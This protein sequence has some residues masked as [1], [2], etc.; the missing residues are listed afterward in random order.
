MTL[1]LMFSVPSISV[2]GAGGQVRRKSSP[3]SIEKVKESTLTGVRVAPANEEFAVWMPES[4]KV[5]TEQLIIDQRPLILSYYGLIQDGTEYAVLSVSG[6]ENKMGDLAHILMLNLYSKLIPTSL[7]DESEKSEVAI[8]ANYQRDI[9]LNGYMGREYSIQARKRTGLWRFYSVGR[10][11]Y[12]IAVSTTGQDNI[13]I[14]RFLNSFT[15]GAPTSAIIHKGPVQP[16]RNISTQETL[17][18]RPSSTETW[19]IILNTFSKAERSKANQRMRLF[20]NLGYDAHLVDTD[21]YP[22]LKKGFL[23]VAMGPHSKSAAE[24]I[25]NKVRSLAPGSYIKSGW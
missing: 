25:L 20:R 7:L 4:P 17:P 9:S 6:L 22:N 21:Y 24:G 12:A 1:L 5:G 14:N 15:L 2:L 19:L 18:A 23:A 10:K 8:K 11:F 16:Q 3:V 13:L